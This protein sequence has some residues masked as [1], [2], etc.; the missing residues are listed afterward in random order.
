[1]SA[2]RVEVLAHRVVLQ[3]AVRAAGILGERRGRGMR[4]DVAR[5]TREQ[6]RDAVRVATVASTRPTR[7]GRLVRSARPAQS[8]R[9]RGSERERPVA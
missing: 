1:M 9:P 8:P 2:Q 5:E 4:G 6:P 3:W 7:I